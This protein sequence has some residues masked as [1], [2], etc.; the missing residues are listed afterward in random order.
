MVCALIV[1]EAWTL[2]KGR[3]PGANNTTVQD[4][5]GDYWVACGGQPIGGGD[6]A[7]WRLTM[8][9]ALSN[10]GALRRHIRDEIRQGTE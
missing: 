9:A 4:I 3:T 1:I 5:C 2:A 8:K 6:P 10:K 7:N